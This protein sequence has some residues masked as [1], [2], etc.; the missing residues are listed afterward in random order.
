MK[1]NINTEGKVIN[2]GIPRWIYLN[3]LG[4]SLIAMHK[5][6]PFSPRQARKSLRAVKR[7]MKEHN[8]PS[9]VCVEVDAEGAKV[10]ID[11]V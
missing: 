10:I 7:V 6:V 2:F 3:Q 11:E 9:I 4:I 8:I 1:L 5:D